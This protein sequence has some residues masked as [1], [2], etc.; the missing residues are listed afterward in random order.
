MNTVLSNTVRLLIADEITPKSTHESVS[1]NT[2]C[3]K[4]VVFI[5]DIFHC[6]F[7]Y[8]MTLNEFY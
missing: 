6:S 3:T 4:N 1:H 5:G 8:G 7:G 2:L